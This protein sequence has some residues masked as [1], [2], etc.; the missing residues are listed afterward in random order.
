MLRHFTIF[1]LVFLCAGCLSA[2]AAPRLSVAEAIR[3]AD[4]EATRHH[5]DLRSYQRPPGYNYA[6]AQDVWRLFYHRKPTKSTA[7]SANEF[8]VTIADKTKKATLTV[9]R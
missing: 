4:T 7:T 3:I 2:T 8:T 6:F 9:R 1:T 5:Y